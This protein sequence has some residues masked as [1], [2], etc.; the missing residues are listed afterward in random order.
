MT[1]SSGKTTLL[2]ET[3]GRDRRGAKS[4]NQTAA[5]PAQRAGG[6]K[7]REKGQEENKGGGEDVRRGMDAHA[8]ARAK[9]NLSSS[10][11][12]QREAAG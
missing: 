4:C 1:S 3:R 5:A 10:A 12:G 8:R 6:K 7:E 2:A 9:R 11:Q